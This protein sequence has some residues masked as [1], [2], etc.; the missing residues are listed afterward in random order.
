MKRSQARESAFILLFETI[1]N[2]EYSFADMKEFSAESELFEID[3]FTEALY[4]TAVSHRAELDAEITKYLKNW[5][6][7]RLS[8]PALAILRL[9][10]A[11]LLYMDDIPASV[12]VNE[13]VEL[14]K[15]Y[16]GEKDAPF[17]NGV[18]GN[19]VRSASNS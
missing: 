10:F 16:A 6:L 3:G 15:K 13:A 4:N 18:L 17:I 1:F 5:R 8:Y 7:E 11:E 19:A 14:A 9:A 12:T 2:P